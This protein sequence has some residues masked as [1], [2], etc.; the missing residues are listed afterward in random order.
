MSPFYGNHRRY[1]PVIRNRRLKAVMLVTRL[2]LDASAAPETEASA[3]AQQPSRAARSAS[4]TR[5]LRRRN[6]IRAPCTK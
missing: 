1:Q 5:N 3:R 4:T 2:R 6:R